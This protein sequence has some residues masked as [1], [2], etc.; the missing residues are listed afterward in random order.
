MREV[1]GQRIVPHEL[2][3]DIE[4]RQT[5]LV[6]RQYRDLLLGQFIEQ[7]HRHERMPCLFH[8]LVELRAVFGRQVQQADH[9]VQ[10]LIDIG[11]A[12]A[13]DGQVVAGPVV[14]QD[15]AV[16]VID[17]AAGRRDRQ[18]VDTVVFGDRR[19]IIEFHHLQ[20][21]QAHHQCTGDGDDEQGTGHQSLVDQARLFFVVFDWNRLGHFCSNSEKKMPIPGLET[22]R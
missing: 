14:R 15:H 18:H 12:F 13:S 11:R 6:D 1:L 3:L 21:V 17:Q 20:Y 16:A 22:V 5:E 19:V 7:G 9:F 4:A 8:R 10:F 2:R